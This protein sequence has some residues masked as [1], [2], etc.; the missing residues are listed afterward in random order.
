M[1]DLL[2]RSSQFDRAAVDEENRTVSLAFS[3]EQP[4]KRSFGMEVL[5]H[6][7]GDVDMSFIASGSAPLLLDHDQKRQIG[8]VEFAG[9]SEGVGRATVRFSRSPLAEEIFNDVKDGIRKNISVGYAITNKTVEQRDQESV[10]RCSWFPQEIS[11]VSVPADKSVGIGRADGEDSLIE[12]PAVEIEI[13][14][15]T[16]QMENQTVDIEVVRAEVQKT[17]RTRVAELAALGQRHGLVEMA[18]QY[19]TDGRGV[20]EFRAA[21]LDE[22]SRKSVKVES[23]AA[24]GLTE[25]EA[26]EF[27]LARAVNALVTGDFSDAGFELEVSRAVAQKQGKLQTRSN[28]FVPA[29][30]GVRAAGANAITAANNPALID[31][32]KQGFMDVLFNKT[33]ASKLGVQYLSGLVGAVEFP[34]FTNAAVARFVGE[35]ADGTIDKVDSD[36]ATMSPRTLI[37]LTELTRSMVLNSSGIEARLRAHLE[38]AVAQALDQDVFATVLADADINWLTNPVAPATFDYTALRAAVNA[39]RAA[40]ALSDN[41]MWAMDSGVANLFE[42]TEKDSN[43]VGIYLRDDTTGRMAGF[44]SDVS[45]SVGNNLIFGDW[46]EVTVG[47][48]STLELSIDSS[49]KFTSG[50]FLLRAITDVDAIVTRPVAFSGYKA[51]I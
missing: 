41:A 1:S 44:G 14:K 21:A 49:Q 10:V 33:I 26:G 29:E 5:S 8:V 47:N 7:A 16:S 38:K 39:L 32:R 4:Y 43:T 31:S 9:I 35:G 45:E 20:D 51:V 27:S 50:G 24:I 18:S 36:T 17:E 48:W 11:V 37:A 2:F 19:I 6:R 34:R 23:S 28:I 46:S 42:T 22:M 12:E 15:E 3:S 30:Y 25:K 40:N 13:K